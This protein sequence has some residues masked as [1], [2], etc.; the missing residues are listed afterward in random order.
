V[1][2]EKFQAMLALGELNSRMK[3]FYDIWLLARQFEYDKMVLAEAIAQTLHD[4]HTALP[5]EVSAF[6]E[7]FIAAKR[8]QWQ[9]FRTRLGQEHVPVDFADVITTL[10]VFLS[11]FLVEKR[12]GTS[13]ANV[14][15][16]SGSWQ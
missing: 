10:R 4:R 3:D 15:V 2:A 14:W 13:D 11:P 1:I 12:A 6:S 5:N 8:G 9:A 7:R 16:P